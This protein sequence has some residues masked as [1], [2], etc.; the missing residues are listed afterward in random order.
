MTMNEPKVD[1]ETMQFADHGD[2]VRAEAW[3][4]F[5]LAYPTGTIEA[6]ERAWPAIRDGILVEESRRMWA[7]ERRLK[8]AA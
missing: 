2:R 3:R 4:R 6:Y 1:R 8:S 7:G 5:R